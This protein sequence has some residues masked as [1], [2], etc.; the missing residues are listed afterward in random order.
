MLRLDLQVGGF[1]TAG[2]HPT[3]VNLASS[4][5]LKWIHSHLTFAVS[6][7]GS[8]PMNSASVCQGRREGSLVI[9]SFLCSRNACH[10]PR[11]PSTPF[12]WRSLTSST[13]ACA[14]TT[15]QGTSPAAMHKMMKDSVWSSHHSLPIC[16]VPATRTALQTLLITAPVNTFFGP[17]KCISCAPAT[18][19][20]LHAL[21]LRV[22][23]QQQKCLPMQHSRICSLTLSS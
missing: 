9:P 10:P 21:L 14:A 7:L 4:G 15:I 1:S 19:R 2:A 3:S 12:F 6:S 23:H 22:L 11:L 5:A 18:W 8:V 16:H 13:S 20:A 17:L